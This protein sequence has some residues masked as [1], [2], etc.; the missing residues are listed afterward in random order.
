MTW[1]ASTG[2]T[3]IQYQVQ[4][5]TSSSFSSI[6]ASS[7]WI[8]GTS[9]SSSSLATNTTYYWRVQA[10]NGTTTTLVSAWSQA[11]TFTLSNGSTGVGIA[12]KAPARYS[13]SDKECSSYCSMLLRWYA[14]T[15]SSGSVEY[16]VQVSTSSSF[17]VITQDSGWITGTSWTSP[18]LK[19]S[20]DYY[21]RVRAR[22][23]LNTSLVSGWST[24]DRFELKN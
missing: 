17:Y 23:G 16:Q 12:P 6:N 21:W 10:R 22:D 3:S 18:S 20:D 2:A 15:S 7:G 24:V 9:W 8:S 4:V 13:V 1:S 5:S 11:G 14:T 19:T